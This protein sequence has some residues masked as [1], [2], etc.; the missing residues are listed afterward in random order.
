MVNVFVVDDHSVVREG[1]V[2][3]LERENDLTVCG[4]AD[5]LLKARTALKE[6]KTD[7]I[8]L[9]LSLSKDNE[10]G[11]DF[12]REL[13]QEKNPI[14]VLILSMYEEPVYVEKALKEGARGYFLKSE[15]IRSLPGA[16]RRVMEGKIYLSKELASELI[17]NRYSQDESVPNPE[18]VLS[19]R[20][21][22]IFE[23]LARGFRRGQIAERLVMSVKTVGTH[24][25]RIKTKLNQKNLRELIQFAVSRGP[26]A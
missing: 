11:L 12:L 22:E 25:E 9:D 7:L 20:E 2:M 13:R 18:I 19:K 4:E 1:V 8:L 24:F 10:T 21:M 3:T 5:T 26:K 17:E 14:P 15:S 6:T 16:I 23:L